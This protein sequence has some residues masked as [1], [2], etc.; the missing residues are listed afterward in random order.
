LSFTFRNFWAALSKLKLLSGKKK[1]WSYIYCLP[2]PVGLVANYRS[3]PN[4]MKASD[5]QFACWL[6]SHPEKVHNM[7]GF[8]IFTWR[9]AGQSSQL[10]KS[11][12][13]ENYAHR[14]SYHESIWLD[15]RLSS[16]S[17]DREHRQPLDGTK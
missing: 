17:Q 14:W 7:V 8:N 16:S 1:L 4:K 2:I 13:W 3:S 5:R 6:L 12:F 9:L 15:S 11:L 10:S